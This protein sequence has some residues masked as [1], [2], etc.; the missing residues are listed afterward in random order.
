NFDGVVN[1]RPDGVGRNTLRGEPTWHISNISLQKTFGFGGPRTD[2]GGGGPRGQ[3]GPGGGGFRGGGGR[4]GF[5][6]G[7]S[8]FNVQFSLDV[9]NPL[10]R[11]I[12]QGYTGNM[13]SPYFMTATGVAQ[14]RRV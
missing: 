6:G 10:N 12:R 2:G 5:G 14:A 11:V 13:L 8:R 3:G 9:S 4:G 1:D 7:D